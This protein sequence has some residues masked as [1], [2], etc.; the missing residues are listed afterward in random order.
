MKPQG[1][2]PNSKP[3]CPLIHVG[4]PYQDKTHQAK[5][6]AKGCPAIVL[7]PEP[8]CCPNTELRENANWQKTF[9]KHSYLTMTVS[10]CHSSRFNTVAHNTSQLYKPWFQNTGS[11]NMARHPA[12]LGGVVC[13]AILSPPEYMYEWREPAWFL[14]LNRKS[15]WQWLS[16]N[17]TSLTKYFSLYCDIHSLKYNERYV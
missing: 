16:I 6:H 15:K 8:V 14:R 3:T 9:Q 4:V 10:R 2:K 5:L 7:H 13:V 12:K 1:S 17:V 11:Q